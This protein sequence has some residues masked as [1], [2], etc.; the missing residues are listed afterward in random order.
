MAGAP[1]LFVICGTCGSE[2]SGYV[3]ECPYCGT[4][5]RKR[6]PKIERPQRAPEPPVR[7]KRS[8]PSRRAGGALKAHADLGRRPVVT[9]ALVLAIA[10]GTI[11]VSAF[12]VA[13]VG[14]VG[15]IDGE[16]W[17]VASAPFFTTNVWYAAA[18]AVTVALFGGLLEQRYGHL[19]VL[20]AFC[21]CGM[22]GIAAAAAL[23]TVPLALGANGAAL[24]LLAIW[25]VRPVLALRRGGGSG[26]D[27][28][29]VAV[30]ALVLLL[31]PVAVEQASPTAGAVGLL[32]GLVCGLL[33]VRR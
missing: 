12:P 33:A 32:A 17:R 26:A 27:L 16:W 23:E 25:A 18:C 6:A 4:R 1:E 31:M 2:V 15:P 14:V 30:L 8:L 22:G 13:D 28:P 24:G 29:G 20:A 10:V 11:L 5:L 9:I 19:V 3:T 21:L 7:R